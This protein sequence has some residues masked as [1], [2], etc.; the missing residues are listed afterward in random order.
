MDD[1]NV[2]SLLSLPYLGFVSNDDTIYNTTRTILLSANN[3][4]YFCGKA[5][6]GIGSPHT[7]LGNIWPMS[8]VMRG[9]TSSNDNEI[10]Q[11]LELLKTTTAGKYFMHESFNKDDPTQFTRSWFAW[12]N[13][14]FGELI[15]TLAK[16]RPHILFG[17]K[18]TVVNS[19]RSN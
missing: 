6:C 18:H 13:S 11:C 5:G 10:I 7:G 12:A 9:L 15:V 1:A 3:P 4:Y 14:M 8:L 2:P 17:Q 16:E 19:T